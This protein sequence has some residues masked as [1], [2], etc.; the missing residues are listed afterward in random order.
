MII[1]RT[2]RCHVDMID[3]PKPIKAKQLQN[4]VEVIP[5]SVLDVAAKWL[6]LSSKGGYV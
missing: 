2:L 5:P 6:R 4:C 1:T 3:Q